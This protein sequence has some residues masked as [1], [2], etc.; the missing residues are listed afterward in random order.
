C[1]KTPG[2]TSHALPARDGPGG[3]G[4]SLDGAPVHLPVPFHPLPS[5][6]AAAVKYQIEQLVHAALATLPADVLPADIEHPQVTVERTRDESHGDFATNIALQLAKPARRNPRQL[7]Q[8]IV[9]AL[10]TSDQVARVEIAGPGFINF[11]LSPLA[12]QEQLNRVF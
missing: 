6:P 2:R 5:T 1:P 4:R 12:Y 8:A 9:D 3:T 10:P 7:A 11:H